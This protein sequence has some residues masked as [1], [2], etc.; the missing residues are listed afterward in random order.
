MRLQSFALIV[1][2][3][4]AGCAG[5]GTAPIPSNNEARQA[6]QTTLDAWKSAQSA[7]SLE[8]GSPKIEAVDFDW[9][10]GK[11]LTE[12]S[13]GEESPGEG[14]KT[15]AVKLTLQP[16]GTKD[17]TYMVLGRDPIRVYRD[18]DFQ[19]MLNMEDDPAT[20]KKKGRR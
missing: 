18:E 4:L 17:V 3:T 11:K 12:Y 14:T 6:L 10:A 20:A 13:I 7:D 9:K 16:G 19:R 5:G 2:S 8:T 15:L 1:V